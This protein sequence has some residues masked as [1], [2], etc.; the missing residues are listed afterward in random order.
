MEKLFA[1]Q[2][3]CKKPFGLFSAA[4]RENFVFWAKKPEASVP[5][6][7]FSHHV[8][9]LQEVGDPNGNRTRAAAVKGQCPNR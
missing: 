8:E 6:G 7:D 5:F 1:A 2:K 4:L 9:K 3:I